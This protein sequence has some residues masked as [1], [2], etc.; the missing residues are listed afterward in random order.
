MNFKWV[1][2]QVCVGWKPEFWSMLNIRF[3]RAFILNTANLSFETCVTI[4]M[5]FFTITVEIDFLSHLTVC[6]FKKTSPS[7]NYKYDNKLY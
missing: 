2:K 4:L 6:I 7:V 3:H 5:I 1:F